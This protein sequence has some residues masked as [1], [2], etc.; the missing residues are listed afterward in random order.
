MMD[1][2]TVVFIAKIVCAI[3]GIILLFTV[4]IP[5]WQ[6]I[7]AAF[8]SNIRSFIAMMFDTGSSFKKSGS[9]QDNTYLITDFNQAKNNF[10][11]Q[12]LKTKTPEEIDKTINLGKG[13]LSMEP[14]KIELIRYVA[15]LYYIKKDYVKALENYE[16]VLKNYPKNKRVFKKLKGPDSRSVKRALA[17]LAAVYYE[18]G[19]RANMLDYYKQYLRASQ[20][21]DFFLDSAQGIDEQTA[22]Y[23]IFTAIA[24]EG[25]L[26][27]QKAIEQLEAL[28]REYPEDDIFYMLG[29]Y[30]FDLVNLFAQDDFKLIE[31][32]FYDAGIYFYKVL[33]KSDDFRK[34]TII[35]NLEKLDK[36]KAR[37][38]KEKAKSLKK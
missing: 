29:L 21:E 15:F 36:I 16:E 31:K 8:N 19:D 22:R 34:Q 1:R 13:I 2:E 4:V 32:N 6:E 5:K 3:I 12:F 37:Y 28:A 10:I 25:Y 23:G 9:R 20:R 38:E 7:D 30:N 27:Y 14:G 18:Q 33:D 35:S 26:S 17:E 24:G 11:A